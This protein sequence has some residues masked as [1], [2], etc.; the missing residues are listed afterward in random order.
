MRRGSLLLS[1]RKF[2]G[3]EPGTILARQHDRTMEVILDPGAG[4]TATAF[5]RSCGRAARAMSTQSSQLFAGAF[6]TKHTAGSGGLH[7]TARRKKLK[8]E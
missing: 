3:M 5:P 7:R 6:P 4:S 1:Q 2:C 8:A